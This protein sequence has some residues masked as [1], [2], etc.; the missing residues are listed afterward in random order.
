[1]AAQR[2]IFRIEE[3]TVA[4]PIPPAAETP[5]PR[6]RN[7]MQELGSLRAILAAAAPSA[8]APAVA[9]LTARIA[10]ELDAV[11]RDSEQ[12]TQTILAAAER[13][14]HAAANL[15]ATRK[16]N[17][18]Q[19]LVHD[20]R[21]AVV[22]IF[23]ACNFQDLTGQRVAKVMTHLGRIEPQTGGALDEL[24]KASAAPVLHGPPLPNDPGH[25]TQSEID[26]IPPGGDPAA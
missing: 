10:G 1:M 25:V 23:E 22:Q 11:I 26:A 24:T 3:T 20:V 21:D 18:E 4:R 2:K 7:I 6:R 13:I 12:A 5:A 19:G 9:G 16:G 17:F 14:D 15:T 8:A